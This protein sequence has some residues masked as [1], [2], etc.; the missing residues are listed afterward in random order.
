PEKDHEETLHRGVLFSSGVIAGEALTAVGI[1]G[2]AAWGI[3]SLDFDIASK[4]V[5][6]ITA[7]A[8]IAIVVA[9]ALFT[10]PPKK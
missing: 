5:T 2:L 3:Q 4:T 6:F 8:A 9:F 1:A 7:L 10:R